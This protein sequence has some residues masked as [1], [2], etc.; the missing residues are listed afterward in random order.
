MIWRAHQQVQYDIYAFVEHYQE[1]SGQELADAFFEEL[2]ALM[3][4]AAADPTR[5]HF[6]APGLRRANMR[7]FPVHFLRGIRPDHV[8]IPV[9]SHHNRHPSY[10]LRRK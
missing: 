5:F 3:D 9:V 10:G 1:V 6:G 4:T 2:I 7:R 8:F